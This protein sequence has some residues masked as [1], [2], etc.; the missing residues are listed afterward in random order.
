LSKKF[1]IFLSLVID[2]KLG[3]IIHE[4]ILIPL[5]IFVFS[6]ILLISIGKFPKLPPSVNLND[7]SVAC[8]KDKLN[9]INK[10]N[11]KSFMIY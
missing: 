7:G 11:K 5:G 4:F 2:K 10:N 9:E 8:K 1:G 3:D 6:L